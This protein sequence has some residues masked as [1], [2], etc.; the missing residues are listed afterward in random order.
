M[1]LDFVVSYSS[2]VMPPT[3]NSKTFV[4]AALGAM[5]ELASPLLSSA[6]RV[7][8]PRTEKKY[9]NF[10]AQDGLPPPTYS[11][12]KLGEVGR[13]TTTADSRQKVAP[14]APGALRA[15]A[16]TANAARVCSPPP[17]PKQSS[18]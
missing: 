7:V 13:A 12:H 9:K 1:D 8:P 16:S 6:A 11:V 14:R 5:P 3:S 17:D 2:Q 15:T 18:R 10:G 4:A